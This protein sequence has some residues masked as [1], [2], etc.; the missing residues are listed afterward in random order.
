M[1]QTIQVLL[2]LGQGNWQTGFPS[3]MVQAVTVGQTSTA[4]SLNQ[5]IALQL[6]GSLPAAPELARLYGEWRLVYQGLSQRLALRRGLRAIEIEPE[7][8][9]HVSPAALEQLTRQIK[10][11]LDHW[12]ESE[13][14]RPVDRR[15][16]T[17]LAPTDEIRLIVE[18]ADPVLRRFPWQLW[19]FFSDYPLAEVAVSALEYGRSSRPRPARQQV[20]ILAV[21]GNSEG[22][23]VQ[24]DRAML[25][26]LSDAEPV[27][28]V[29]PTRAELDQ[30]LWDE[31]GWDM[32]FFSG[33]SASQ[34]DGSTGEIA[35]N[36]QEQLSVAQLKHALTAAIGRG[37]QFAIFNS[38]DG[39]GLARD[40]ADLNI[41]QLVV[42][43]E[44]VPDRVAQT[45]LRHLLTAFAGGQ[46][47]YCAVRQA[48]AKLQGLESQFP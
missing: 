21:L 6:S 41:P 45:F 19:Q 2:K 20:R 15:L 36:A 10:Q 27:F 1:G 30:Q 25:A 9:T 46:S 4:A 33:H 12:L 14:F 40:M 18:T 29:E 42:M 48:R 23:D 5:T 43:R 13:S 11:A 24:Q 37:L 47:F 17:Q 26:Q 28:L 16:R 44:P 22:I 31:Q 32:L 39:L 3:V 8:I 7:G 34:P 35:I 38:C